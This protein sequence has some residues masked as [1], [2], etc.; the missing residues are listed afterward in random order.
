VKRLSKNFIAILVSDVGRRLLGFAA[1]AYLTRK[2]SMNDFGAVNVGLSLLS[3]GLMASSGGLSSFGTRETVREDR[4]G[5]V[6]GI[7][8]ARFINAVGVYV[9]I[10]FI[11]LFLISNLQTKILAMLFCI[12]LIV[13][14]FFLDWYFQGKES[15][16]VIGISRLVAAV[17]YLLIIL[18]MVKSPAN[19]LWI[20][21]AANASDLTITFI[22]YLS[23]RRMHP[24]YK[25]NF[26]PS[27]WFG[28]MKRAF[29]IG[30]GSILAHFSINLPPLVI[31]IIFT[32][33]EVGIYSAA[34]KLVFFLLMLDR[35]IATLLLPASTRF[36]AESRESLSRV[37]ESAMKWIIVLALPLGVGGTLLAHR[38]L[39]VVFGAQYVVAAGC[40]RILIWYFFFTLIHTLF[41]TGL[42]VI[43]QEKLFSKLM[44][45]S[46]VLYGVTVI[47]GTYFFGVVGAAAGV[48]ISEAVTVIFMRHRFSKFVPV[49]LP[50]SLLRSVFSVAVMGILLYVLPP[51]QLFL[52]IGA[53][54]VV[55]A[56]SIY[57]LKVITITDLMDILKRV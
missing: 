43:N 15:M 52:T 29:P 23:Y 45:V 9:V 49:R 4:P 32:N 14:A 13:N 25:F 11:S 18:G 27:G 6:N 7:L 12:S 38:I 37:L 31:G 10:F 5:L 51:F 8:S 40:F 22:L 19:L 16:A 20:P 30:A 21:F 36:Y 48:V 53:G 28:M 34:G 50:T 3:Y 17:V 54:A 42:V 39:P 24:E 33:A 47:A 55:Y 41:S 46:A 57:V 26:A 35:V 44:L 1:L 56:A 2:I